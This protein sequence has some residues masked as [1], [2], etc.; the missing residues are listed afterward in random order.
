M[1]KR[2]R[3]FLAVARNWESGRR[4][5]GKGKRGRLRALTLTE[6]VGGLLELPLEERKREP[7]AG[8]VAMAMQ[9]LPAL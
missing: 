5:R 7:G 1:S 8:R 4:L 6:G 9:H 3:M 2:L